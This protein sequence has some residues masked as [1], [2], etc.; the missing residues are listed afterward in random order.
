VVYDA[1]V[2]KVTNFGLFV[3]VFDV[4]VTGMIHIS[5]I[6]TNFVR[7]NSANDS[8]SVGNE[9]YRVGTKL[10]VHV[11]R[12]DFNQRRADFA[13]VRGSATSAPQ[14]KLGNRYSFGKQPRNNSSTGGKNEIRWPGR[15]A[16]GQSGQGARG[17]RPERKALQQG[18]KR[19]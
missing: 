10:K 19:R 5:M 14:N 2:S 18:R 15:P 4:Q 9:I 17:P 1:V 7:H 13:L 12:I 16:H 11:A 3:D 8:L 6:S